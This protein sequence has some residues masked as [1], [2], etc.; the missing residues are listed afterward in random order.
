MTSTTYMRFELIR[1]LRNRRFFILSIGFP[2]VLFFLIAGPNRHVHSL[3]GSGID[4]P[5]YFM[6]GLTAFGTMNSVISGGARIALDRTV[7]WTR[8]LRLTPLSPLSYLA[9]KVLVAYLT[10]LITI[11]VLAIAG[12]T[13]GVHLS[14][15]T[16]LG[17]IA[18]LLIGLL[19]FAA[20]GILYGHLLGSDSLGPAVGG[21][22]ALLAFL[23]G[24]WFPITNGTLSD[25]AQALPSYWLTQASRFASGG[26]AWSALG[27]GV[28]AA[29]TVLLGTAAAW[30]Y[31][32]DTQRA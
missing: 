31:R 32:R 15:G 20:M 27:W 28:T 14:A 24:T 7:G 26:P 13:L 29:W 1:V 30:A 9:T 5:L 16:W 11:V 4:A 3:G 8:Q 21:T 23:G 10:A 17:T 22:T 2:L 18:L 25:I 12:S 6:I 19:P